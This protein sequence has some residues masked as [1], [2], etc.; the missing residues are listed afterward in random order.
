M[1]TMTFAPPAEPIPV[2]RRPHL[3][4]KIP[5]VPSIPHNDD[6]QK[7]AEK[8]RGTTPHGRELIRKKLWELKRQLLGTPQDFDEAW[9]RIA[10]MLPDGLFSRALSAQ[11]ESTH[12]I[13]AEHLT[14]TQ[15]W[16]AYRASVERCARLL[17]VLQGHME[18]I[19]AVQFFQ[20]IVADDTQV[21]GS[22]ANAPSGK[23][24]FTKQSQ[25]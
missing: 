6:A 19:L 13:I 23:N 20:R 1:T 18:R 12:G 4:S 15:Q 11:D 7:L 8:W 21:V 5:V 14:R 10:S 22:A 24:V 25:F 9:A 2:Q 16:A 17:P 3:A